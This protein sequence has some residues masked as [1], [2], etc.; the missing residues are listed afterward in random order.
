MSEK[1]IFGERDTNKSDMVRKFMEHIPP[2]VPR[3]KK[4]TLCVHKPMVEYDIMKFCGGH[5]RIRW[6]SFCGAI[7]HDNLIDGVMRSSKWKIPMR[8]SKSTRKR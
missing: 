4:P 1:L 3:S 6:C 5:I 7:R 8:E 2:K